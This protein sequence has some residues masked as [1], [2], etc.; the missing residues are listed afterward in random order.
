M[1]LKIFSVIA[2]FFLALGAANAKISDKD[3]ESIERGLLQFANDP[4]KMAITLSVLNDRYDFSDEPEFRQ[5][6]ISIAQNAGADINKYP[7]LKEGKAP[8]LD[9]LV[10]VEDSAAQETS[11]PEA[12]ET[13]ETVEPIAE[14]TE[15]GNR[16]IVF[17]FIAV[18]A[19]VVIG[20]VVFVLR[21]KKQF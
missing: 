16:G 8:T 18:V 5:K 19:I 15:S 21:K 3:K 11:A 12:A 13:I 20:A 9:D 6:V 4:Q 7:N 10:V 1:Y 17:S 2:I 14:E